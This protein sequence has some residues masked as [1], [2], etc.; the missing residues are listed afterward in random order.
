MTVNRFAMAGMLI[1]S[2]AFVA[3]AGNDTAVKLVGV[4]E[5]TKSKGPLGGTV[6]FTKEGK[7]RIRIKIKDK[8]VEIDGSYKLE[9][10][11]IIATLNF[12]GKSKTDSLKIKKLNDTEL[13]IEDEK[14]M[15]EEFKRLK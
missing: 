5:V 11:K 4:W 2:S 9:N 15:T 10:E 7:I 6:E 1:V 13:H 14:G 3:V 12:G 8:N